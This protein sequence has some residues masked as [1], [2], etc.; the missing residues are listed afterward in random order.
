M[1][2]KTLQQKLRIT[3]DDQELLRKALVHPS[4][5]EEHSDDVDESNQRMEFLGDACLNFIVAHE[6]YERYPDMDEGTLTE[7][8]SR[9]VRNETLAMIARTLELG[10]HL[11]LGRGEKTNHGANRDSNLADA[12]EALVAALFLDQGYDGA[13][14]FILEVMREQLNVGPDRTNLQDPKTQLQ[15]LA[16]SRGVTLPNYRVLNVDGPTHNPTYT[17]EVHWDGEILGV[18]W[19]S[20]KIDAERQAARNAL[21]QLG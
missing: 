18:G 17:V 4:Y 10:Q 16:H 5:V 20:R 3:F 8:R 19:G 1:D 21:K 6:L 14:R 9:I 12:F 13:R 2:K 11:L 15:Q 7:V